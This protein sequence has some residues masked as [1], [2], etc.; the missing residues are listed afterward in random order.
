MRYLTV[1]SP[2]PDADIRVLLP[3]LSR[4]IQFLLAAGQCECQATLPS[5]YLFGPRAPG[6]PVFGVKKPIIA[7]QRWNGWN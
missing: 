3:R 5:L 4:D 7:A 1:L 6:V 2:E